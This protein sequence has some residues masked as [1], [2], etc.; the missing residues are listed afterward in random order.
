MYLDAGEQLQQHLST[1]GLPNCLDDLWNIL[2]LQ[3][4]QDRGVVLIEFLALLPLAAFQT[5]SLN[6]IGNPES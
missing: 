2:V 1:R 6:F 3:R 5:E 4:F